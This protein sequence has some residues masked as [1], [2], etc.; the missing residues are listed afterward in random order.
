M[1]IKPSRTCSQPH[2]KLV[3]VLKCQHIWLDILNFFQ[4]YVKHSG[5][6]GRTFSNHSAEVLQL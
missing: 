2:G 1:S 4:Q 3:R 5:T 6:F